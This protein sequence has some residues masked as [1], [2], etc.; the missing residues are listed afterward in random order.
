[1]MKL[2]KWSFVNANADQGFLWYFFFVRR[3]YGTWASPSRRWRVLHYYGGDKPW[4]PSGI[5]V[6]TSS[7]RYLWRLTAED[8]A[9]GACVC[10]REL[11]R[12]R[13][14]LRAQGLW[15]NSSF[16]RAGLTSRGL[17][18]RPWLPTVAET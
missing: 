12:L 14:R 7:S 1:M 17:E 2:D 10:S 9:P 4:R 3:S 18:Q 11:V 6:P 5:A 16:P 8:E 15:F 13:E